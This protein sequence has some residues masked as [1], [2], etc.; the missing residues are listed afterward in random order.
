[1]DSIGSMMLA[2]K[3]ACTATAAVILARWIG[4]R[5]LLAWLGV[6][7]A[8]TCSPHVLDRVL[9]RYQ[10]LRTSVWMFARLKMRLDPMF[11]ELP[12]LLKAMP[13]PRTIFDIG[14]GYG[15]AGGALLEWFPNAKL[16]GIDPRRSRV[17]SARKI[18]GE[19]GHVI[20]AAAP[21]LPMEQLPDTLDAVFILDVIHYLNDPQ[22][23]LT[24]KRVR[25]RLADGGWLVIRVSIPEAPCKSLFFR[26]EVVERFLTRGR[27]YYRTATQLEQFLR[28]AG[29]DLR[30][31]Q[32]S[33]ADRELC[34]FVAAAGRG[35]QEEPGRPRPESAKARVPMVLSGGGPPGSC[36][37]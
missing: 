24:L 20:R 26:L 10:S 9:L 23:R 12:A 33:G 3:L 15:M 6:R 22:L 7:S 34:W 1:V 2:F 8:D 31:H 13:D 4:R 11:R 21:D 14:C 19:R 17:G 30:E 27:A 36:S 28:A 37:Y 18:F 5:I 25:E 29:F 16:I 32:M 35:L